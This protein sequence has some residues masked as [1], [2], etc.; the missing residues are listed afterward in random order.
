MRGGD[1][2]PVHGTRGRTGGRACI[3]AALGWTAVCRLGKVGT[4]GAGETIVQGSLGGLP[5]Q[6][7]VRAGYLFVLVSNAFA[8]GTNDGCDDTEPSSG[9]LLRIHE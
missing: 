2:G 8:G 9:T 6:V 4:D 1:V 5:S 3:D 7:E